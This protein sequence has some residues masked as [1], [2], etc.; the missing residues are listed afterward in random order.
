MAEGSQS[1]LKQDWVPTESAFRKFLS[2]LDEGKDS[3]GERYLEMRRRLV[4]Y[5]DRKQCTRAD[6][7]AD[8]T[9]NRVAR[10]LEEEGTITD[11]VP[12]QYCYVT[13]KFVFMEHLRKS[14]HVVSV[15]SDLSALKLSNH[16]AADDAG[17]RDLLE[18]LES[19]LA[20]LFTPDRNL[21]L[22]YYSAE[23]QEKIR[24]RRQLAERL[25]LTMNALS[26][27]ASRI[28]NQ[29]EACVMKCSQG[30]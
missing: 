19:C 5:F 20:R 15:G 14:Q 29:L 21:I 13:A 25:S 8:E 26:I 7:L 12:A 1:K 11:A 30:S 22:E 4:C 27:R 3:N 17:S 18:C 6:E 16:A 10:R 9:L 24:R 2:W 28:R 23:K